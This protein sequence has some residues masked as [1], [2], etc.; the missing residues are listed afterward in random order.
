ML[1][2]GLFIESALRRA[3]WPERSSIMVKRFDKRSGNESP[4]QQS[5]RVK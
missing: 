3:L 1:Q 5:D 4:C 2:I